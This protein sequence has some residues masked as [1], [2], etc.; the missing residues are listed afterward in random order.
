MGQCLTPALI[1]VEMSTQPVHLFFTSL[2]NKPERDSFYDNISIYEQYHRMHKNAIFININVTG[3]VRKL[4][5]LLETNSAHIFLY[6]IAIHF[7][8][9][10]SAVHKLLIELQ[11]TET[12]ENWL[13]MWSHIVEFHKALQIVVDYFRHILNVKLVDD[14]RIKNWRGKT[15]SLSIFKENTEHMLNDVI[16]LNRENLQLDQ[17][18]KEINNIDIAI[19][20]SCD[21]DD[22]STSFL[23]LELDQTDNQIPHSKIIEN[24]KANFKTS[25]QNI[26]FPLVNSPNKNKLN[27]KQKITQ[28][29]T[30]KYFEY[31]SSH[32]KFCF[33]PKVKLNN[34]T[35]NINYL[36]Q[37]A[38]MC[39]TYK[40]DGET[41]FLKNTCSFDSIAQIVFTG[42]LDNPIYLSKAK[43]SNN[44]FFNFI[45]N[46]IKYG[47]TNQIYTE[48]F[49]LLKSL[50]ENAKKIEKNEHH[51][52]IYS[53]DA[54]DN[55]ATVW[56]ELLKS[57]PSIYQ[58]IQCDNCD[59]HE[60]IELML[61]PINYEIIKKEG[62]EA[63]EKALQFNAII[64]NKRCDHC[65][66]NC[67]QVTEETN[68]HIFIELAI[69]VTSQSILRC[70]L[71]D[72]PTKLKLTKQYRYSYFI[73]LFK[74]YKFK[75]ILLACFLKLINSMKKFIYIF[76]INE[77]YLFH[78]T[79]TC[80]F[81]HV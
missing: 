13:K 74:L 79:V 15:E 2:Q 21:T 4:K 60:I 31:K 47:S 5:R 27:I 22:L 18:F 43:N 75:Y 17:I 1:R 54:T 7:D 71:E 48:R 69:G 30:R 72:L 73:T 53:Y 40:I 77:K 26:Q 6:V 32:S 11:K 70:K 61:M 49:I 62:F 56:M 25:I 14:K 35:I 36:L 64:C 39:G 12:I 57:V 81:T 67:T 42:I 3:S 55:P 10:S 38:F 46:F 68:Y 20:M 28:L 52:N 45:F 59:K 29:E 76:Y 34:K 37:N 41:Y 8:N 63:L 44:L 23:N 16:E 19:F 51:E 24:G 78:N 9:M 66:S 65:G 80:Q 50:Y 33:Y 58:T